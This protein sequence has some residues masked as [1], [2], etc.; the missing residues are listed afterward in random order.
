M[1]QLLKSLYDAQL[2]TI[3][4]SLHPEP[5][6]QIQQGQKILEYRKRFIH[7]A[8][9]GFVHITGKS[10]G[11]SLF[12]RCAEPLQA[13]PA[14]LAELGAQL[15]G[16]DPQAIVTYLGSKGLAIPI[17]QVTS[18]TPVS[19][20]DLRVVSPTFTAPRAFVYLDKPAQ[21]PLRDF[22]LAQ[23]YLTTHETSWL[24][25]EHRAQQILNR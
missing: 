1:T 14:R 11:V 6:V 25:Q 4:F 8:F 21:R 16:D 24:A 17:T 22:L 20:A 13:P 5:A 10:G 15:Q 12:L 18:L 7:Q 9:Q 2:P 23:P 3:L 19:L